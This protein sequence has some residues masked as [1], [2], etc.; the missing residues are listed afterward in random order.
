MKS[1]KKILFILILGVFSI[2][3]L[4]VVTPKENDKAIIIITN[5]GF[6]NYKIGK[7]KIDQIIQDFGTNFEKIDDRTWYYQIIYKELGLSFSYGDGDIVYA[8]EFYPPFKGITD[9]GI[10]LNISTMADVELAYDT[11][12][13][14]ISSPWTEWC[15][16][17][18]GIEFC[19]IRDTSLPKWP[20]DEELHK[21][22]TVTRIYVIDNYEE[23]D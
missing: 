1:S 20:L 13:W 17:Y 9:R 10:E 7:T 21:R 23:F 14:Y 16:M 5:E 22:K 19:S 18:P 11:L 4:N 6:K 2:S 3:F 15:S 8:I 12:D